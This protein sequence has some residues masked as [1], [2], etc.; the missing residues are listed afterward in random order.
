MLQE[1]LKA[2][3]V[4]LFTML[5]FI[6]GP[7]L[8]YAAGLHFIT[9]MVATVTGMMIAVT[10]FTYFGEW[11]RNVVLARLQKKKKLFTPF[12]RKLAGVWRK[13]GL[14]VI[15]LLTPLFLTPIGGTLLAVS[16]GAAKEKILFY[17]FVSATFW[18]IAFTSIIYFVGREVLPEFVK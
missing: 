16:S 18:A 17:M 10:A 6:L 5:K 1:F 11:L 2:I 9:T 3:P 15:A 7:S 13:N 8:G 14:T 12:N 4:A